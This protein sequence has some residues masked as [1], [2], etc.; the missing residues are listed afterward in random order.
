MQENQTLEL[1]VVYVVLE[2]EGVFGDV[3][4]VNQSKSNI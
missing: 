4:G 1:E 3:L 2:V